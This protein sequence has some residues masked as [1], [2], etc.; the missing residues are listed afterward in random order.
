MIISSVARVKFIKSKTIFRYHF[1]GVSKVIQVQIPVPNWEKTKK[2]ETISGIQNDYKSGKEIT[3]RSRDSKL[4][5]RDSKS[6]QRLQIG[7]R[8]I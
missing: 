2:W 6:G 1:K 8:G 5:Q 7:V 3:N 4:G